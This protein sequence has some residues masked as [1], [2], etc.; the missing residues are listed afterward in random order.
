LSALSTP[1]PAQDEDHGLTLDRHVPL[2]VG[3][4]SGF[5]DPNR[6]TDP[7]FPRY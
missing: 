7:G 4:R 1:G 2:F 6:G 5:S 3:A